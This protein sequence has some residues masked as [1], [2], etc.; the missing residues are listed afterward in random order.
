V[1]KNDSLDIV[2]SHAV[3]DAIAGDILSTYRGYH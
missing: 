3:G 1:Q 2:L